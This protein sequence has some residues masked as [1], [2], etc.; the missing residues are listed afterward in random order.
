MN[1]DRYMTNIR[2]L[3]VNYIIQLIVST[4][5]I[6]FNFFVII[7]MLWPNNI[8][9]YIYLSVNFYGLLY[10][11]MPLL[12][13]LYIILIELNAKIIK[14]CKIITLAFCVSV[15]ITG[16]SYIIILV[17]NEYESKDFCRECPFN[18]KSSY[19]NNIYDN[20]INKK[21]EEN[22]LEKH[23]TNKRCIFNKE[24]TDND[25]SSEYVCNYD[26]KQEFAPIN[27]NET[28]SIIECTQIGKNTNN[29]IFEKDEIYK[30]FDMCNSF[31]EFYICHRISQ[32]LFYSLKE[33]FECPKDNYDNILLSFSFLSIIL[34]S[35]I[36]IIPWRVEY[37]NYDNLIQILIQSNNNNNKSKSLNSTN[38]NSK[39]N[40]ENK[41][42]SFKKEAT[43][44]IIVYNE[45]G[46]NM[47]KNIDNDKIE[48]NIING[49]II[50]IKKT[51]SNFIKNI[52]ENNTKPNNN[53]KLI[54]NNNKKES[55]KEEISIKINK[56]NKNTIKKKNNT[57]KN[58]ENSFL[59]SNSQI[60]YNSERN[61]FKDNTKNVDN[62]YK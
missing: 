9:Y 35:I 52:T 57:K 12:L 3:K 36:S 24:I 26:P 20:Y 39:I 56:L 6:T 17:I 21:I 23:C 18:L 14:I 60:L 29:Y 2:K 42:E 47:N 40:Q 11:L 46:K 27:K 22:D 50:P 53:S 31:D 10:F 4:L 51:K 16:L 7:E 32:P 5:V 8:L 13:L 54:I 19:I 41:E 30:F 1:G 33:D 25:Y 49:I 45:N 58:K 34:N 61:I 43:E 44:T 38:N 62:K 48:E 55:N 59:H 28:N 15:I 37:T